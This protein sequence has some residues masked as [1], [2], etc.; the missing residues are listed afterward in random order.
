MANNRELLARNIV[1]RYIAAISGTNMA[2]IINYNPNDRI[3]VGKLSPRSS[4]TTFSSSVLIKQISVDFRIAKADLD[5]ADSF[6][7]LSR[8]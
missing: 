6:L 4:S 7:P 8:F 2:E 3:Y 5:V 1:D